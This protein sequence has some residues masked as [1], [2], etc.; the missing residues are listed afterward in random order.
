MATREEGGGTSSFWFLN[1]IYLAIAASAKTRTRE[2]IDGYRHY[3]VG[4]DRDYHHGT[5]K[6][7]AEELG[8]D[9]LRHHPGSLAWDS[10]EEPKSSAKGNWPG[11]EVAANDQIKYG[12]GRAHIFPIYGHLLAFTH[13]P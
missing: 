3:A 11:G 1:S 8:A 6:L 12:P 13:L 4:T 9:Y 2:S 10:R 5:G 7:A